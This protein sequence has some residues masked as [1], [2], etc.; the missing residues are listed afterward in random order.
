MALK[1][2]LKHYRDTND[3]DGGLSERDY[4]DDI[5]IL[6]DTIDTNTENI[7]TNTDNISKNRADIDTNTTSTNNNTV[8]KLD[9]VLTK[10]NFKRWLEVDTLDTTD[11]T[12]TVIHTLNCDNKSLYNI[13]IYSQNLK[14]DYSTKW[15]FDGECY[16]TIDDNK[17]ITANHS[18]A[19]IVKDDSDWKYNVTSTNG[20]DDNQAKIDFK[21]TG[22]ADTNIKWSVKL[23]IEQIFY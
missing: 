14:D 10:D 8:N 17:S 4:D 3:Y 15:I 21:V 23:E 16:A 9:K 12:E 20:D 18:E 5:D 2:S 6:A 11:D 13:K 22:K 1:D 7:A 19:D